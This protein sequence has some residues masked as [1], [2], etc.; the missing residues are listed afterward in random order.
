MLF[1]PQIA[2]RVLLRE[3][4][5]E[6]GTFALRDFHRTYHALFSAAKIE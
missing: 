2:W 3:W 1:L 5:L 6:A 4:C